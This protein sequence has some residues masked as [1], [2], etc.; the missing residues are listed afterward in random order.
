MITSDT[1]QAID[2]CGVR[3]FITACIADRMP[4]TSNTR[5]TLTITV[6]FR[7]LRLFICLRIPVIASVACEFRYRDFYVCVENISI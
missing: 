2:P 3:T 6:F 4:S 7:C 1:A 5:T